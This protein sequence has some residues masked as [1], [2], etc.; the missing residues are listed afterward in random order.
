MGTEVLLLGDVVRLKSGGPPMTIVDFAGDDESEAV[1]TFIESKG[2]V[3]REV[4]PF[5]ALTKHKPPPISAM[6]V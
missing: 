4:F 2:R 3:V 5:A 1:C 6:V